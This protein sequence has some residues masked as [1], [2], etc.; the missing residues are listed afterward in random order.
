MAEK[1]IVYPIRGDNSKFQED[2]RKTEFIAK[3]AATAIGNLFSQAFIVAAGAVKNFTVDIYK[4]G[5]SFESSK[6]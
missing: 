2:T 3:G 1:G 5:S 4:T 6:S